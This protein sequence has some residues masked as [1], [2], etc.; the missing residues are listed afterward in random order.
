MQGDQ[1]VLDILRSV[2]IT[3]SDI[4]D[5]VEDRSQTKVIKILVKDLNYLT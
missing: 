1:R 4:L 3:M 2:D 5:D